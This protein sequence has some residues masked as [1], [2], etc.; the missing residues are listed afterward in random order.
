MQWIRE[1][2]KTTYSD[3]TEKVLSITNTTSR[4]SKIIPSKPNI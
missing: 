3:F 1:I 2:L 4:T